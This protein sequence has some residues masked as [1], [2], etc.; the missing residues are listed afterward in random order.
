MNFRGVTKSYHL[1]FRVAE[2]N[3][4]SAKRNADT[5][6]KLQVMF[7][8]R[9]KQ[10]TFNFFLSGCHDNSKISGHIYFSFIEVM[11]HSDDSILFAVFCEK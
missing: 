9:K 6:K 1:T 10:W 4:F 7:V 2:A 5:K 11:L 8:P 3:P